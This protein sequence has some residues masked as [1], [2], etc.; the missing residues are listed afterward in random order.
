MAT[1]ITD[2]NPE[3]GPVAAP[4]V[5]APG[6]DGGLTVPDRATVLLVA[7]DAEL[8]ADLRQHLTPQYDV[9]ES[10]RGDVGLLFARAGMPDVV[11]SDIVLPGLDGYALCRAL[12]SDPATDFI[13]V[14]L[15]SGDPELQS[16]VEGF[17]SGADDCLTK[18]VDPAELQLRIRNH[19]LVC[20][21]LLRRA[22][23]DLSRDDLVS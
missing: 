11:I 9:L 3:P 18:P 1:R 22:T 16:R 14:I 19:L 2:R 7:E 8:R 23:R 6:V 5:A 10:T 17:R 15:I 4:T 20:A 13:P 12:K 21:S